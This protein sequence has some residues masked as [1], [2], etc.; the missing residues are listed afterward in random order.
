ESRFDGIE[1]IPTFV[2][3]EERSM[4]RDVVLR[5][6]EQLPNT[7]NDALIP[8]RHIA[9]TEEPIQGMLL[10]R[11]RQALLMSIK[12]VIIIAE[13]AKNQTRTRW[14]RRSSRLSSSKEPSA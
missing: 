2:A 8:S 6:G 4:K 13:L 5:C 11:M 1:D 3:R 7:L 14:L 12:F 9:L 10:T